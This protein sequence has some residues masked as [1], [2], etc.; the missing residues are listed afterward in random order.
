MK[1]YA[2]P[3]KGSRIATI[4]AAIPWVNGA[5]LQQVA[6]HAHY[7]RRASNAPTQRTRHARYTSMKP[8]QMVDLVGQYQRIKAEVDQ[9][10]LNVVQSAAFIN[11][12]EVKSF[13]QELGAY[14]HVRH[15]IGCANGTD[16]LQ[17]AMMAWT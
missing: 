10:M 11:G 6:E 16:A 2:S 8:I 4:G 3:A 7:L 17:I 15:T 5:F 14:L 1:G 13:E 12:P 9:A